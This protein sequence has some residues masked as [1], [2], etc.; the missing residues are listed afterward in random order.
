MPRAGQSEKSMGPTSYSAPVAPLCGKGATGTPLSVG[1]RSPTPSFWHGRRSPG[2][3][4]SIPPTS[5]SQVFPSDGPCRV[6]GAARTGPHRRWSGKSVSP[7]SHSSSLGLSE[8]QPAEVE[9]RGGR[10]E[11][12]FRW[13]LA[14]RKGPPEHR[15]GPRRVPVRADELHRPTRRWRRKSDGPTSCATGA[16]PS[17]GSPPP[18]L[19]LLGGRKSAGTG[20]RCRRL[21]VPARSF[22]GSLAARK[23]ATGAGPC[24]GWS[25]RS[26]GPT[27]HS[28]R[29]TGVCGCGA[30]GGRSRCVRWCRRG[31]CGF[32]SGRGG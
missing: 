16:P 30:A 32:P 24:T 25:G 26:V 13:P 8:G 18:T 28:G 6:H 3:G 31:G 27:S 29:V 17:V 1:S 7:A 21:P 14:A 23:G 10:G 19:L 5:H 15:K 22:G 11:N 20:S 9:V 4:K 2:A 12:R